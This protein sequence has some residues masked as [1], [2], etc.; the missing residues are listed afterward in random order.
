MTKTCLHTCDNIS[1]SKRRLSNEQL[2]KIKPKNSLPRSFQFH[3]HLYLQ[4][5]ISQTTSPKIQHYLPSSLL[6]F[7]KNSNNKYS[8][9]KS[10]LRY[11]QLQSNIRW[12]VEKSP[13]IIYLPLLQMR[14]SLQGLR[15]LLRKQTSLLDPKM[16]KEE[17]IDLILVSL[18]IE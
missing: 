7:S 18:F 9:S 10:P 8:Q 3:L 14:R 5:V 12:M 13:S 11:L 2:S 1:R 17:A 16:T 4:W 15:L 6:N